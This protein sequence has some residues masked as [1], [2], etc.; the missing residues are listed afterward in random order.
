MCV[1]WIK[2][3][4]FLKTYSIFQNLASN[5]TSLSANKDSNH[6]IIFTVVTVATIYGALLRRGFLEAETQKS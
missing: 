6:I 3:E 4:W 1:L 2:D 5:S